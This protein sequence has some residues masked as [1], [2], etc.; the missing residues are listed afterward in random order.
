M[1]FWFVNIIIKFIDKNIEIIQNNNELNQSEQ[2]FKIE[3]KAGTKTQCANQVE[4]DRLKNIYKNG[5]FDTYK[6]EVE[7]S[8]KNGNIKVV[9]IGQLPSPPKANDKSSL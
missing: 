8:Y 7:N 4:I 3:L 9:E 5:D 6:K 2:T 1:V